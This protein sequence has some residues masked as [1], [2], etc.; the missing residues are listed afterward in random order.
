MKNV[1]YSHSPVKR[2]ETFGKAIL[3]ATILLAIGTTLH[4]STLA[5]SPDPIDFGNRGID[6]S[7][8]LNATLTN[9]T[10]GKIKIVSISSS[11]PQ[12][13]YSGPPLPVTLQPGQ[14]MRVTVTFTPTV[15]QTFN[16]TLTLT[17][18]NGS[19]II[20]SLNGVGIQSV[21]APSIATQPA[22]QTV[23][24]G[25]T[26]TFSVAATGTAPLSYQWQKNN[27]AISG[28]TSASYTT[29][30]ETTS[31]SGAQYSA[32]VSNS[33]GTVTSSRAT[34][35]VN[36][37]PGPLSASTSTLAFGNVNVGSSSAL[38]VIF[39]NSSSYRVTI[40]S[41]MISGPGFTASGVSAGLIIT[42]GQTVSL[43]VTF[44]PAATGSVTGGVS[45]VSNAS[46]SPA[47]ISLSGT[48]AP[49][50]SATLSWT[51]ST[52][53]IIGYN[54]YR[55]TVSGGP[56]TKINSSSDMTTTLTDPS[57]QAGKTYYWVVTA[58]NSGDVEST[59]SN[60]VAATIPTP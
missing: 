6:T 49:I 16:G 41:V 25:Q 60:E 22:S 58:V 23:T 59:Y 3:G 54:V 11:P 31:N 17:R 44:V 47:T 13:S 53:T 43:K 19:T 38:S 46:N 28:A 45:V 7:T 12:F 10:H 50:H 9:G 24:A 56:Y 35:T 27:A 21:A 37:A 4:A 15:A 34:L 52:S 14:N 2:S 40:S 30:A 8:A 39:T 57:I 51:A 18:A 20:A 42:A 33:A 48:G 36:P 32:M 29:P 5:I 55:G 26:A 1:K